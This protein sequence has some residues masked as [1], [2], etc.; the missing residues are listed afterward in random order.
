MAYKDSRFADD[1]ENVL[2]NEIL[3]AV[4]DQA[5]NIFY[6]N[7][8]SG[9]TR[10]P[11]TGVPCCY[12]N[13]ARTVLELPTWTY[14]RS[15][16]SIYLN[17]FI[18]STMNISNVA[19]TTV[20]LVQN[21]QYPWTNTDRI[22]V[23]PATPA[24][25]TLCIREPRR[26]IS[27]LYTYTPSINGLT[28]IMLNGSAATFTLT[29][30]YAA[31]TRTWTAGDYVDIT[32]PMAVQRVKASSLVAADQGLVALQYG[33]LI[34]NIESADQTTG[35]VLDPSATLTPQYTNI[36]GGFQKI[37]GTWNDG[38]TPFIAIPNYSRL[39]RGG[40]SAVWFRDQ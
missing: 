9:G 22:T 7:P 36:L 29:N 35:L 18:G 11:W 34:Y 6:P 3:G 24:T 12:G 33:P 4:D 5:T 13:F 16:N 30:G 40:S 23:N 26:G 20:Q 17:L 2:Y 31:I 28:S 38:V 27:S 15:S 14:L 25:F 21:T 39:N 8:L 32:M 37:T 1:M 10:Q 19:G